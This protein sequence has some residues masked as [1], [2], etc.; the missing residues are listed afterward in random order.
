M[1]D[2][3]LFLSLFPTVLVISFIYRDNMKSNINASTKVNFRETYTIKK[4]FGNL[5]MFLKTL[6]KNTIFL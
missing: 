5:Y 6:D 2:V 3:K 4:I 1:S